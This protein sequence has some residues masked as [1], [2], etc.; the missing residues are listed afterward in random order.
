MDRSN[1]RPLAT[2]TATAVTRR[3]RAVTLPAVSRAVVLYAVLVL[4]LIAT[5]LPYLW[6][7]SGS[8]KTNGEIVGHPLTLIP[9]APTLQNYISLINESQIPYLHQLANSGIIAMSV[10]VL[11]LAVSS[12]TGYGFAK[13]EFRFKRPLFVIVLATLMV[14]AQ[15]TL[16]PLF[17][18]MHTVGWLDQ[19]QAVI[20]PAVFNAF[21]V[22]FMRQT[23]LAVP[24]E[25]LEAARIDGAS[26]L[27]LYWQIALPLARAGLTVLA[28]LA[29]LGAWNEFLWPLIVLSSDTKMT[30]AVGIA[31]LVGLYK[32]HYGMIN[33]DAFLSTLPIVVAF[34]ILRNQFVSG[35]TAGAFK[36]A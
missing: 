4:V 27:R 32:V 18:L 10:V 26:E 20:V 8:F 30:V 13:F 3:R 25:L 7:I 34:V 29:F 9:A 24:T 12:L 35:L 6:M 16:V 19:L 2:P 11:S 17:L 5:V 23:M 33:A 28:I 14:P 22:F 21:G 15:I 36:G 31:N 1:A